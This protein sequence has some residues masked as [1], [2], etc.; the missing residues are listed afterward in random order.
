MT[1]A[2][3]LRMIVE[4]HKEFCEP[5]RLKYFSEAVEEVEKIDGIHKV[6]KATVSTERIGELNKHP[7]K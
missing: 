4:N 7:D 2:S 3:V 5:F 6:S 1:T